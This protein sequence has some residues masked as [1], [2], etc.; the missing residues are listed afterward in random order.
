MKKS[1]LITGVAGSG[2]S[3][4]C[5]ELQKRGYSAHDIEDMEGLFQ[6]IDKKTGMLTIKHDN[7]NLELVEQ[8][9]WICDSGKLKELMSRAGEEITFYCGIAAD[10]DELLPLFDTVVLLKANPDILRQR[11]TDRKAGDFGKTPEVQTWIMSWK[12]WWEN[13]MQKSGAIVIDADQNIDTVSTEI[14]KKTDL[15]V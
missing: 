11:L 2:K 13:H 6:M 14:I 10:M 8:N 4:V 7:D 3:A 15:K 12:D 9:Q 5:G 1:I